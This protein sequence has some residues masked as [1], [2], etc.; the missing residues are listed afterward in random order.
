M[1]AI[2]LRTE[3]LIDPIGVD[4]RRPRLQWNAEGGERQT[5][6]QIVAGDWDSGRVESS[7]MHAEY[8][9]E[10]RER[11]RV[12]WRVRLW[13]ETGEPG[14]WSEAFFETGISSCAV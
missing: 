14:D 8:P 11:E 2:R 4:F 6:F 10:L 9:M 13:D 3:Y 1:K 5:A 12:V 7:A